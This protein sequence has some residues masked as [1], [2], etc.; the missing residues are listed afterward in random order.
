MDNIEILKYFEPPGGPPRLA[1]YF[2][3]YRLWTYAIIYQHETYI[4]AALKQF[5][6]SI[7]N[8]F[9]TRRIVLSNHVISYI[10][11]ISV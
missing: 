6:T 10:I 5:L 8:K 4:A 9:E 2:L 3:I 11:L 1:P 7:D